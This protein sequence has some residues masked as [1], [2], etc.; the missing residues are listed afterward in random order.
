[1][2]PGAG[3]NKTPACRLTSPTKASSNGPEDTIKRDNAMTLAAAAQSA[4]WTFVDGDW[5][6]GNVAILGPRSHA[7]WLGTS[8]FDGARWF[9]GVAPDLDLH[10]KR[11]NA[12][13][14]GLGLKPTMSVA[15][16]VG[17]TWDGLKRFD[18]K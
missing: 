5:Y 14:I 3:P 17:L 16:I 8:V 2:V 15:E 13:A 18:G 4:T 1:M 10:V 12:S 7:M 9:E 11:V 6:E